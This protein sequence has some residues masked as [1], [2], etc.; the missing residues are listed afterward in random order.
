MFFIIVRRWLCI[1]SIVPWWFAEINMCNE[2]WKYCDLWKLN[3]NVATTK[4]VIFSRGKTRKILD[5]V[6]GENELEVVRGLHIINIQVWLLIITV[7][8]LQLKKIIWKREQRNVC[9]T[10]QKPSV[11]ASNRCPTSSCWCFS[12]TGLVMFRANLSN[13]KLEQYLAI[14]PYAQRVWM[15]RFRCRNHKLPIEAGCRHGVLRENRICTYCNVEVGDGFH[16]L[17]KCSHFN[18]I[19]KRSINCFYSRAPNSLK[20]EL[21]MNVQNEVK[22]EKLCTYVNI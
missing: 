17:F 15:T 13:L 18:D 10:P 12:K 16:Y 3:V 2:R 8:L 22:M 14:L 21:L 20:V 1:I 6:L 5:F 11:A 9:P 4:V 19:Q 7:N